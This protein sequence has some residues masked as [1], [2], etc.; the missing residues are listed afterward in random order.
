M[1]KWVHEASTKHYGSPPGVPAFLSGGAAHN[2]NWGFTWVNNPVESPFS[3]AKLDIGIDSDTIVLGRIGRPDPGI[4]DSIAVNGARL[5]QMLGEKIHFL[6]VATPQ[7]MIDDL[8]AFD[9]PHT[10]IESTVDPVELSEFYNTVDIYCHARADGETFGVNIAEAMIHGK[11][12]ITHVATQKVPNM[13]V[14][15]S[16]TELVDHGKTGFVCRTPR[17]YCDFIRILCRDKDMR[18]SFGEMGERKA[19]EEYQIDPV[20]GKLEGI[21]H[22]IVTS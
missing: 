5:A 1:A 16:Q 2:K 6:A 9:I 7:P 15:Q 4:Y 10:L 12:V 18:K 8:V 17:E 20:V 13:S 11:P 22:E 3:Q 21:Y 14:F 19:T